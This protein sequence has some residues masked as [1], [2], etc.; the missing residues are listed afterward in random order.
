MITR[1]QKARG[2]ARSILD[3]N[4]NK[5]AEGTAFVVAVH[6]IPG[7]NPHA[8]YKTFESRESDIRIARQARNLAFHMTVN[9]DVMDDMS[10]DDTLEYIDEMM[11]RLGYGDQ[12]YVVYR[13]E[14]IGRR[15]YHVVSST[16]AGDGS[17]IRDSYIGLRVLSLQRDLSKKYGFRIGLSESDEAVEVLAEPI[18]ENDGNTI[19]RMRANIGEAMRYGMEDDEDEKS[20]KSILYAY[21]VKMKRGESNGRPYV[22]FFAVNEN[23]KEICRA[24]GIKKVMG[25]TIQEFDR[26]RSE[27]KAEKA[28]VSDDFIS[29]IRSAVKGSGSV[30]ELKGNLSKRDIVMVSISPAGRIPAKGRDI[31]DA[32][33]VNLQTR[34]V[35]SLARA[36]LSVADIVGLQ[37]A[38]R[39]KKGETTERKAKKPAPKVKR[40]PR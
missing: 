26:Q 9:P 25:M 35:A 15:H 33:F 36:G 28:S 6:G 8:I 23:G 7:D 24:V 14:D 39:K 21:G 22:S 34:E 10:E 17:L 11:E 5:C 19:A 38:A 12:P 30:E 29:A 13:H 18:R 2:S 31:G 16:V 40:H 3:Y 27:R 1:I 4:E 32:Y 37:N 20:F